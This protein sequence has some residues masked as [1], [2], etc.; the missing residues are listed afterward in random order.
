MEVNCCE[1]ELDEV[2]ASCA[3]GTG[4]DEQ[5]RVR[6]EADSLLAVAQWL[7]EQTVGAV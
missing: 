6:Q 4:A 3:R 2:E 1:A 5:R 7:V